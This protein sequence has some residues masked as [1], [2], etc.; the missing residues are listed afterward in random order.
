[1]D[2]R[3]LDLDIGIIYSGERHFMSPLVTSLVESDGSDNFRIILVDNNSPDGV[4]EWEA[5][6]ATTSRVENREP[7]GYADNLNRILEASSAR[8]VLLMNT[9]MYFEAGSRCLAKMVDFLDENPDCGL[10]SCGIYHPDGAYA[11]PARRFQTIR[12]IA[13]R[14]LGMQSFFP[15]AI[16]SYLCMDQDHR[17]RVECDWVSGCFM[18]IRRE[19]FEQVGYFDNR[20]AKY[21]E[22]VDMCRRMSAAGWRVMINGAARCCHHEQRDSKRVLSRDA[23]LH[24]QSYL[25]WIAKWGFDSGQSELT[26][27]A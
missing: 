23:F 4:D 19:A 26:R 8:Y 21:F 9:D 18:M 3:T 12:A 13:A 10:A 6:F 7:L 27:A 5:L 20:F 15:D 1:M 11:H 22:D 2:S 17:G 25:R 16:P 24:L 14:R